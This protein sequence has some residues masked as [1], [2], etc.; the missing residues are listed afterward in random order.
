MGF[1]QSMRTCPVSHLNVH[2]SQNI[3]FG[4]SFRET[5]N[6]NNE[7]INRNT[8]GI[9]RGDLYIWKLPELFEKTFPDDERVYIYDYGCSTGEEPATIFIGLHT[10]LG[11]KAI[12][13]YSPIIAR[14][15]D[16]KNIID[17]KTKSIFESF[18]AVINLK[19]LTAKTNIKYFNINQMSVDNYKLT[20]EPILRDNI[21][22]SVGDIREDIKKL[23]NNRIVLS[24]RNFWP[25]LSYKD[26]L[27]LLKNISK[28]FTDNQNLILFGDFDFETS[29]GIS[30]S[31]LAEYN[32]IE[33]NVPNVFKKVNL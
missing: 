30:K 7:V 17:A 11:D 1:I 9:L 23:P 13:K 25:Y 28:K 33:T 27:E 16:E 31:M 4:Y 32:I 19:K 20:P 15:I 10:A 14:D 5:K 2:N 26:R 18:E 8:T 21:D 22:F 29:N 6:E 12:N 3:N 24:C